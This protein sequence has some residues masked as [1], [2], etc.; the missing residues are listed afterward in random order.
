MRTLAFLLLLLCSCGQNHRQNHCW[1]LGYQKTGNAAYDSSK[2]CYRSADPI[3]GI[4]LEFLHTRGALNLYLTVHAGPIPPYQGNPKQALVIFLIEKEKIECIAAR[5]EGGG[6]LL[7]PPEIQETLVETFK[8]N[9][10]VLIQLEGY[11][12]KIDPA[13]FL[14]NFTKM[15]KSTPLDI[16]FKLGL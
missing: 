5:H 11:V 9:E 2:L 16:P 7:L 1:A 13:H 15:Q 4:D 12:A 10:S 3:N 6:R 8:K 14:K